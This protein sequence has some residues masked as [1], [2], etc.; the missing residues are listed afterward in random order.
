LSAGITVVGMVF[1]VV[2]KWIIHGEHFGWAHL[3]IGSDLSLAGI[4]LAL[5]QGIKIDQ[6]L[7]AG[8]AAV[9]AQ[10]ILPAIAITGLAALCLLVSVNIERLAHL[11]GAKNGPARFLGDLAFGGVVAATAIFSHF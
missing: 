6:A 1:A 4:L 9:I 2:M 8:P 11:P 7:H 10:G 3:M 5:L